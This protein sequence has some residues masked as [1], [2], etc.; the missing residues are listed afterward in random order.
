M[1]NF[2]VT[3][4]SIPSDSESRKNKN[5]TV[6]IDSIPSESK[7]SGYPNRYVTGQPQSL[8]QPRPDL[9][10]VSFPRSV[11]NPQTPIPPIEQG[12]VLT[13]PLAAI[14]P[15]FE[16]QSPLLNLNLSQVQDLVGNI[17]KTLSVSID[18]IPS[19]RIKE[20][21]ITETLEN[22]AVDIVKD[23]VDLPRRL[24]E[25]AKFTYNNPK[26]SMKYILGS[27]EGGIGPLI[28]LTDPD[29]L[30]AYKALPEDQRHRLVGGVIDLALLPPTLIAGAF[31]A[32]AVNPITNQ[33]LKRMAKGAISGAISG[34]FVPSREES[35][36]ITGRLKSSAFGASAGGVLTPIIGSFLG[37]ASSREADQ[38]EKVARRIADS[39]TLRD[40]V[41]ELLPKQADDLVDT[42]RKLLS[43]LNPRARAVLG[44]QVNITKAEL[45]QVKPEIKPGFT[46]LYRGEYSG[47]K[48]ELP[49]WISE[50]LKKSG[51]SDATGRWFTNERKVANWYVAEAGE[52]GELKYID[53]PTEEIP[54]FSVKGS[55]Q[56]RFS[57]DPEREFFLPPEIA[58]GARL[59]PTRAGN[60]LGG[61]LENIA[62]TGT[63]QPP[64]IR[65]SITQLGPQIP[66]RNELRAVLEKGNKLIDKKT[67]REVTVEHLIEDPVFTESDNP[68]VYVFDPI[69]KKFRYLQVRDVEFSPGQD[70][71]KFIRDPSGMNVSPEIVKAAQQQIVLSGRQ[72][73]AN[74]KRI[75]TEGGDTFTEKQ[76]KGII[77]EY[78]EA[79]KVFFEARRQAGLT[80]REFQVALKQLER[81]GLRSKE[82]PE[83]S[84]KLPIF[85]QYLKTL[86][87]EGSGFDKALA[88]GDITFQYWR[89]NIF[90][91]L[92]FL[93]DIFTN[94]AA[95]FSEISQDVG[96]DIFRAVARNDRGF[97]R[98]RA[99]LLAIPKTF[100]QELP[101]KVA[102][103]NTALGTK[104]TPFFEPAADKLVFIPL[105]LKANVDTGFK[106]V[107][108]MAS[109][110]GD[111]LQATAKQS[112]PTASRKEFVDQFFAD[113]PQESIG[114]AFDKA[115]RVGF[116]RTLS[117]AEETI[118]EN[119]AVQLLVTPFP[120]WNFQFTRFLLEH[121]PVDAIRVFRNPSKVTGED[122]T[123][124]VIRNL[125]GFGSL[126]L[127]DQ[128]LYDHV[129]FDK[130]Q[131]VHEDKSVTTLSGLTPIPE[132]LFL[133]ALFRGDAKKAFQSARVAS[134]IV[135]PL[136]SGADSIIQQFSGS[137]V[138]LSKGEGG[139]KILKQT[140]SVIRSLYPGQAMLRAVER[141]LH[142]ESTSGLIQDLPFVSNYDA[143]VIDLT[144]GLQ[145]RNTIKGISIGPFHINFGTEIGDPGLPGGIKPLN[146]VEAEFR[147]LGISVRPNRQDL[148]QYE[149]K[150]VPKNLRRQFEQLLGIDI[151]N[152][153]SEIIDTPE[154]KEL[155]QTVFGERQQR[156]ILAGLINNAFVAA[157][158][159]IDSSDEKALEKRIVQELRKKYTEPVNPSAPKS[160]ASQKV[161][162]ELELLD[163]QNR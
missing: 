142:P 60:V 51:S 119:R 5:L 22:M 49:R 118:A 71:T 7:S 131:Y 13:K 155:G 116:S 127:S 106:R 17:P 91:L 12:T 135:G 147:R 146:K 148:L 35:A 41:D 154:Y 92:S 10:G 52:H 68:L 128:I 111:A 101:E 70:Y 75:V 157:S 58:K 11:L 44:G 79:E 19:S 87:G 55:K 56:Q 74:L 50:G 123:R 126:A 46:R 129:D 26:V 145:K 120:R 15:D 122:I 8:S 98:T 57:L 89:R 40:A 16:K 139:N 103:T 72:L 6:G 85:T 24:F 62:E 3:I 47:P 28:A 161:P 83:I 18:A 30:K 133:N 37:T 4:D 9:S 65:D 150:E 42:T 93:R 61:Q 78:A 94:T 159:T 34:A 73:I 31:T 107:F 90:P 153:V 143:P 66:V 125:E 86:K 109:L 64:G 82:L 121:S 76:I 114:K 45:P 14:T 130:M 134:I 108:A 151:N 27:T 63:L 160:P 23:T 99:I 110:Y 136:T 158:N 53:I 96:E 80:L 140:E 48:K 39:I 162:Q 38:V 117:S 152:L 105:N 113:L 29:L 141:L 81:L 67:G 138:A 36:T 97:A 100:G 2:T 95:S 102:L 104:F 33:F 132:M 20:D 21:S 137:I 43:E 25:V 84:Q 156:E 144:T 59:Y 1:G 88:T 77:G 124:L 54:K 149:A 112:I 163:L 32:G 115:A 69:E